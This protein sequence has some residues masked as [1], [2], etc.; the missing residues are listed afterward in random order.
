MQPSTQVAIIG[1]GIA[2]LTAAIHLAQAG[3]K[4]VVFEKRSYPQHKVCGEYVSNEIRGYYKSLGLEISDK[5]PNKANRFR[6]YAPSGKFIEAELPLGGFGMRR[7]CLDQWLV[8]MA[9]KAGVQ[10]YSKTTIEQVQFFDDH[11]ELYLQKGQNW[12]AEVV[13]GSF[14]KK[15][16]LDKQINRRFTQ[17]KSPYIG[18]KF[19]V[20]QDEFPDDLVALYNF[21]GGY[22]GAVKVEDGTID[23]AYLTRSDLI[24]RAKGVSNFE[25][26][27]LHQNPAFKLLLSA[28]RTLQKSMTISNISFAPKTTIENHILMIGDAAG[29]IP[30]LCGNGMAMGVHAAKLACEQII[31]F[32][33]KK[34]DRITME[35]QYQ[36]SWNHH[37]QY[38]LFWGRQLQPFLQQPFWSEMAVKTLKQFPGLLPSIIKQTHGKPF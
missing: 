38:R 2:G 1:G 4:V 35:K 17:K 26:Q 16:N 24:K 34:I 20:Q 6:L 19:Y 37:F 13:I 3:C 25:Q 8:E 9:M 32:L 36:K 27:F 29:M 31:P 11:F 28:P 22:G 10:I 30:P 15:S 14:G 21:K 5:Q 18:V 7:F 23:I 12:K 33:E